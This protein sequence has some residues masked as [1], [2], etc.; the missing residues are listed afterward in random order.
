M[1]FTIHTD[2]FEGFSERSLERAKKMDRGERIEALLRHHV[3][4]AHADVRGADGGARTNGGGGANQA[5]LRD[6][7]GEEAEARSEVGAARCAEAGAG[8]SVAHAAGH[9]SGAWAGEDRGAGGAELRAAGEILEHFS[10]Y[11]SPE[12]FHNSRFS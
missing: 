1:N 9:Q 10:C 5:I 6:R 12:E 8:R 7:A 4:V 2:G 11:Y 3:R